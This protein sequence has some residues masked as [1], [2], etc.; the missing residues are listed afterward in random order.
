[1]ATDRPR[2]SVSLDDETFERVNRF[3]IE[4]SFSTRSKAVEALILN[5]L[6]KI[7]KSPLHQPKPEDP[8]NYLS[9][10]EQTLIGNY[11]KLSSTGRQFIQQ[12]MAMAVQSY[13]EKNRA[14]PDVDTAL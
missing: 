5:A 10:D 9:K 13:G 14:V 8:V 1:M 7:D 2:F 3:Q 11:R 4:G 12:S 6:Q